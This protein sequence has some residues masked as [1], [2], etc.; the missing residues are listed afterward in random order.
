MSQ[1]AS[2]ARRI[3]RYGGQIALGCCV[4]YE[5]ISELAFVPIAIG[6]SWCLLAIG[7]VPMTHDGL[8]LVFIEAYRRAYHAG[9]YFPTW[10]AFGSHGHGTALPL[11]YHRLHAQLAALLALET[12]TLVAL[13]ISI[14]VVLS[15]GAIGMRRLC[16]SKGVRPWV[17]WVAGVL[18]MSA[19]YTV[20]DWYI[21]GATSEL[22]A[23]MLVPWGL[24]YTYE[25]FDRKWGAVRLALTSSLIFLAHMM[26]FY[27]FAMTAAAIAV[28]AFLRLT[29]LGRQRARAA[30][31]RGLVV[32]GLITCAIG[33]LAA[34]VTYA[35]EFGGVTRL[36]MRPDASAYFPWA[37]YFADPN[38]SWSR[39]VVEGKVSVEIGR[40]IL[41]CLAV[42]LLLSADA[43][44]A[45]RKRAGDLALLAVFFVALQ[46][47]QM[48]FWFDLLP[49]A[50]K[51]Q[52]PSRLLVEIVPIA[53]LCAA[54]ATEAAL[55]SSVPY[56]RVL[57]RVLPVVAALWQSNGARGT[58]SAIWRHH[59]E[60]SPAEKALASNADLT[61]DVLSMYQSWDDFNPK[62]DAHPPPEAPYLEASEGCLV[63]LTG[64]FPVRVVK[65]NVE[66]D[67]ATFTVVGNGCTVKL[68]QFRSTLLR[69]ELSRPG[70]VLEAPDHSTLIEA[71]I[72]G[73]VVRVRPR[74]VFDLATKWFIEKTRRFP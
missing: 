65:H 38:Y 51:I 45:V 42:F 71:P 69:V 67:A 74:S 17:A 46:R 40:W 10:T 7:G 1:G 59:V 28:P 32:I 68:D 24:R 16:R 8:G 44:A 61:T 6:L 53:I 12:G 37:D 47:Q 21:R 41:L 23:F 29:A 2:K 55:R 11:L 49:G 22:T 57:A 34:A 20:T 31:V 48:A 19:N 39:A 63:S 30:L 5:W 25:L 9:E 62:R 54:I 35:A 4:R 27:F 3:I 73:T 60:R 66:G 14:P 43:R 33:P 72:D 26:T 58:Q 13:K 18:L 52:F 56:V 64:A 50:S 36:G 15:V 70:E